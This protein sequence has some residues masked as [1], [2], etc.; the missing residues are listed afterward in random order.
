MDSEVKALYIIVTLFVVLGV[1]LPYIQAAFGEDQTNNDVST[2][3]SIDADDATSSVGLFT[4]LGS[5]FS[6][7]FWTFGS[8]PIWL[9]AFLF[10][11]LRVILLYVVIR[12]ARG[13]G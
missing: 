1:L 13:G 12:L 7:F 6:M 4:V 3:T 5:V 2:L 8:L 11:P 10:I 9:D